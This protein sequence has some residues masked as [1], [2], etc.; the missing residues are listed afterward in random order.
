MG[1]R[2]ALQ[3]WLEARWYRAAPIPFWLSG[4]ER[5]FAGISRRR[6]RKLS[7]AAVRLSKPVIVVGN[8]AIGGSGKTPL[9]IALVERLRGQGWQPGVISRGYGGSTRGVHRVL[10]SDDPAVTGDEPL[11]IAQRTGAP[12]FIGRDRVAAG[13]ALLAATDADIVIADDGLQHYRLA[14]DIEIAVVDGRRRSGNGRLLPAGPLRES[15]AR[16]DEVDLVLV[17]GERQAGEPGFD[18]VMGDATPLSGAAV[19]PLPAFAATRVHAVAGIGDP[20][21]FFDALSAAG[22]TV[23][24]HPFPDH[25][26]FSA[27]DLSFDDGLPVLMTEKDAVKCRGIAPADAYAVPVTAV[28]STGALAELA[29]LDANLRAR[30]GSR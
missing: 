20:G 16:L 12:V 6:R 7:A 13:Q 23:I 29:A 8:I 3:D 27:G 30:R 10:P 14:R 15:V 28:L 18:L 11:L 1:L 22:L 26:A 17:N 4:L 21:R 24:A 2:H 25:Y 5:L 9:T 19:R